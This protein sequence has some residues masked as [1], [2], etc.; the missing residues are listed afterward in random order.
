[1]GRFRRRGGSGGSHAPVHARNIYKPGKTKSQACE[2]PLNKR[3]SSPRGPLKLSVCKPQRG[4]VL[5]QACVHDEGKL[6]RAKR[7]SSPRG[8][9]KLSVCSKIRETE[10]GQACVDRKGKL[11][12]EK[13][14][15]D[16]KGNRRAPS[17]CPSGR[18]TD[19]REA[20]PRDG[21]FS[22]LFVREVSPRQVVTSCRQCQL[23]SSSLSGAGIY[24]PC[25][26]ALEPALGCFSIY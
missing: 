11:K 23:Q 7:V 21:A 26:A 1:M 8:P 19:P 3:V 24:K 15:Y 5:I 17:V 25:S 6:T 12:R 18:E 22:S 16:A 20:R 9:L 10:P 13:R 2:Q 14:V 4:T